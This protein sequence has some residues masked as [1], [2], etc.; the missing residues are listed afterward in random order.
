MTMTVLLPLL[1]IDAAHSVGDTAGAFDAPESACACATCPC[2]E[3]AL[4]PR[5][6]EAGSVAHA[7]P[8]CDATSHNQHI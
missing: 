5:T 8:F 1:A 3:Q 6:C 7:M 2:A 4:L